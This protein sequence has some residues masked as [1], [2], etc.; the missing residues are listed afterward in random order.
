L[1]ND[2]EYW[3][4][5][6]DEEGDEC[7]PDLVPRIGEAKVAYGSVTALVNVTNRAFELENGAVLSETHAFNGC[8]RFL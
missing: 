1:H 3:E 6:E 2:R 5:V 8:D 4:N 7:D